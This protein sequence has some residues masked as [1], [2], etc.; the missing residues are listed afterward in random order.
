MKH[1]LNK[2]IKLFCIFLLLIAYFPAVCEEKKISA[3]EIKSITIKALHLNFKIKNSRS[4]VY[5]I[6]WTKDLSLK[7]EERDLTIQAPGFNSKSSWNLKPPKTRPTLEITGPSVPLKIFALSTRSSLSQWTKP[8]FISSFKGSING[9]KNKG[10][11]EL[12]LKEGSVNLHQ[13]EGSLS[14]KG[15]HVNN[16]LTSSKGIFQFHIN[17]GLLQVKK[18]EGKLNFTTDKAKIK[19]TQFKG[20]LKGFSQSGALNATIKP[21]KVDLFVKESSIRL[22]FMGQAPKVTAYTE[23]GKIYG[24]NYLYKKF[25]GKSTK[26]SG[27]IRGSLKKGEVSLKSNTGNIYIN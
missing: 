10:H 21:K 3:Q 22:Y 19:L 2:H 17:E 7:N 8:V 5:T 25:S 4:A 15:F 24:P 16:F 1:N 9:S 20:S 11:W 26:V 27:Q 23:K 6:K 13:Q 14:V 12:S 18:S